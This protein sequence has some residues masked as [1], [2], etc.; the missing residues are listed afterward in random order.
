MN[1]LKA[2]IGTIA[3][4]DK[5][6]VQKSSKSIYDLKMNSLQGNPIHLSD[7]KGKKILF[8]N[9]ASK[10]GYTYQ[11]EGLESLYK[12]Y[13]DWPLCVP[14]LSSYG[15][16]QLWPTKILKKKSTYQKTLN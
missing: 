11:Y 8:V 10:C 14:T 12:K 5:A 16:L 3:T 2:F 6:V 15:G 13:K 1:P 9:V 7:F 4:K